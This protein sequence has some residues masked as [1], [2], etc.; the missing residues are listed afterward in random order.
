MKGKTLVNAVREN[1]AN[2]PNLCNLTLYL[3]DD[4]G[5]CST[6]EDVTFVNDLF[7]NN[8]KE[9]TRFVKFLNKLEKETPASLSATITQSHVILFSDCSFG[10]PN[11]FSR[12]APMDPMDY[13]D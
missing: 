4:K 1:T 3:Y 5:N 6:D 12:N 2:F 8:S 7:V 10:K 13:M 9:K 11:L